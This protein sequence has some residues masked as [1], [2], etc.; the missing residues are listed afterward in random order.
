MDR[1]RWRLRG[2]WAA[3]WLAVDAVLGGA[4]IFTPIA[5]PVQK[6][7]ECKAFDSTTDPSLKR[8]G[9]L[10]SKQSWLVKGKRTSVAP[11]MQQYGMVA[12]L[13]FVTCEVEHM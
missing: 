8:Y 13:P 12:K 2:E 3:W 1:C 5:R 7:H 10:T 6:A 11:A 9:I 4:L